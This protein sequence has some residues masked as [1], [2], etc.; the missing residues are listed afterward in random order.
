MKNI[1]IIQ[2]TGWTYKGPHPHHHL[3]ERMGCL[4]DFSITVFDYDIYHTEKTQNVINKKKI[5][6]NFTRTINTHSN[7]KIIRSMHLEIP[8]LSRLSS[9]FFNFFDIINEMKNSKPL[10]FIVY[11][12]SNGMVALII[13][14]IFRIPFIFHYYEPLHEM[15]SIK[16]VQKFARVFMRSI[17]KNS[18]YIFTISKYLSKYV[19]NEGANSKKV[20]FLSMSAEIG[21]KAVS[22]S[23]L[24][25]YRKK[26]KIHKDDF[27]LYYMGTLHPFAGL[28]EI[29]Q[30][31]NKKVNDGYY[32]LKFLIVGD[33][34]IYNELEE[35]I[36]K[37]HATTWVI[38]TG[39]VQYTNIENHIA[40]ATLCLLPFKLNNITREI[41]PFKIYEYIAMNKPVLSTPLPGVLKEFKTNKLVYFAK[42]ENSF[43]DQI[44][45]L[46][47]KFNVSSLKF[48]IEAKKCEIFPTWN[49]LIDIIIKKIYDLNLNPSISSF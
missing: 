11:S 13:S 26:Y 19:I 17:L 29:I 5:I 31:F 36:K 16:F 8:Y 1:F 42:S 12:I 35:L 27:V 3:F 9:C 28:I 39:R 23:I 37:I 32:N 30:F 7:L 47:I 44:E 18:N 6:K 33:K 34:G 38:L 4:E 49:E 14:K 40:L 43:C 46:I 2:E 41:V 24:N 25:T 45:S 48:K 21:N 15:I 22:E 10:A 20:S